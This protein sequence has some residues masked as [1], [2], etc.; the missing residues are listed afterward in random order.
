MAGAARTILLAMVL[1]GAFLTFSLEPLTGRLI[2]P[3]FGGSI[4]VWNVCVM[5]FQGL[6]FFAAVYAHGVGRRLPWAHLALILVG[7]LFLPVGIEGELA[8]S[9]PTG[10]LV[11]SLIRGIGLPFFVLATTSI[12]AQAWWAD[13]E[14]GAE[15]EPYALFAG[16]NIGSLLALFAYPLLVERYAGL[17]TQRLTWSLGY[18]VYA[19]IVLVAFRTLRPGAGRE[20]PSLVPRHQRRWPS[21]IALAAIP[22]ALSLGL[23]NL[24]ASELGSFPLFWVIP[25]ALYLGSF[26]VAFREH[27]HPDG[28]RQLWPDLLLAMLLLGELVVVIEMHVL[29]YSAFFVLCWIAHEALYQRRPEPEYLTEFYIVVAAGG[30]LGGI[31]VTLLA[32]ALFNGYW[33]VPI[34]LGALGV[35]LFWTI[36]LPELGWWRRVHIRLSG[37]RA[38]LVFVVLALY[39]GLLSL[40]SDKGYIEHQ[41]NQYGVFSVAERLT[42]KGEAFRELT[43]GSTSHGKQY[44]SPDKSRIPVSY[45]HPSG[46]N[47]IALELR[48]KPARLA[49]V[50]L[51]AGAMAAYLEPGE[52]VVFYEI[53]P[54]S[55]DLARRWFRYLDESVGLVEVRSGDARLLLDTEVDQR[56][57]D[58]LFVDAFAGDGIPTHLLTREAF[59]VYRERLTADGLLIIHISNRYYDLRGVVQAAASQLGWSGAVAFGTAVRPDPR[60]G[61]A[62]AASTVVLCSDRARLAPLL[63]SG[64]GDLHQDPGIRETL[65]WTDDY[66]DILEPFFAM[67][68]YRREVLAKP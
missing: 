32:P 13:S 35:A 65:E 25:L 41:R 26:A 17:E 22:S 12:V 67:R 7:A 51:G 4:H 56:P 54:L 20:L 61:L 31:S 57:Y 9:V 58:V 34:S 53:N 52:S 30:W 28:V 33:E 1:T 15:K 10:R 43:N 24:V 47:G 8:P 2:S 44:L 63:A 38:V 14:F 60:E 40:R 45:Y 37:S 23:T 6:F 68:A 29:L 48:R 55:T 36:G 46:S 42:E 3:I 27:R 11:S 59:A 64:W 5:V 16:S 66:L 18:V 50:G 62:D 19:A 49:G 39:T 21:W